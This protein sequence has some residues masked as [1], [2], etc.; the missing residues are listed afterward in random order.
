MPQNGTDTEKELLQ[1]F[2][3]PFDH[4]TGEPR[5]WLTTHDLSKLLG[6]AHTTVSRWRDKGEGPNFYPMAR[7]TVRYARA[8]VMEWLLDLQNRKGA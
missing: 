6:V 2:K 7:G 5:E 1:R 8:D 3:F 4:E